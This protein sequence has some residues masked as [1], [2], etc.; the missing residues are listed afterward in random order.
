MV[1]AGSEHDRDVTLAQ[2]INPERPSQLAGRNAR[3]WVGSR[4]PGSRRDASAAYKECL[5]TYL[6]DGVVTR[7]LKYNHITGFWLHRDELLA[8]RFEACVKCRGKH[9]ALHR[10]D[11]FDNTGRM[12]M[13]PCHSGCQL[14]CP[15]ADWA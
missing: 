8:W 5:V 1:L 9:G 15:I 12:W 11:A 4:T 2:N 7:L 13:A 3:V 6:K 10:V 14:C